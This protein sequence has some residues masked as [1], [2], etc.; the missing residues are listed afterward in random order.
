VAAAA[1]LLVVTASPS[2]SAA[3][4]ANGTFESAPNADNSTNTFASWGE[5]TGNAA[6]KATGTSALAGTTSALLTG[7]TAGGTI[8]T[9]SQTV[10]PITGGFNLGFTF[11]AVNPAGAS[12]S[13]NDRA[14]QLLLTGSNGAQ[15]NLI[16]IRGSSASTGS[17][18][19][20]GGSFQP[21]ASQAD[22][23]NFSTSLTSP[24]L[25]TITLAGAVGG[26]YTISTNGNTS[27]PVTFYQ[28]GTAATPTNFTTLNFTTVN[29]TT[30]NYTVD[31]VTLTPEPSSALLLAAGGLLLGARRRRRG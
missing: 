10:D 20:F 14:L 9:L 6:I 13:T 11:A 31:N 24:V 3:P 15:I 26:E 30:Q 23:V 28:A 12:P 27:G 19:V 8:G 22:K 17:V 1:L 18:Q 5:S 2:A 25:N 7:A 4:L 21:L 16:V 29:A